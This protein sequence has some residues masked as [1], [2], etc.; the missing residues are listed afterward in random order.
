M[1]RITKVAA[2]MT[3]KKQDGRVFADITDLYN[4]V[5]RHQKFVKAGATKS[6]AR[7]AA[8][9]AN[10]KFANRKPEPEQISSPE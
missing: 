4:A 1:K 8:S 10:G 9:R 3:I 2:F 6:E 7:A 5:V